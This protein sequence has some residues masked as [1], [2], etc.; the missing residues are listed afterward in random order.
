MVSARFFCNIIGE[1]SYVFE[2]ETNYYLNYGHK[3]WFKFVSDFNLNLELNKITV[4]KL[5]T[6]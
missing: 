4:K 3:H 1:F 5:N 6:K 2:T